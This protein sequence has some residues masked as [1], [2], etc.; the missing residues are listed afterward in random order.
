MARRPV[1]LRP[2]RVSHYTSSA[3]TSLRAEL[4]LQSD[5]IPVELTLGMGGLLFHYGEGMQ[6]FISPGIRGEG[7]F[8]DFTLFGQYSAGFIGETT[9][10]A[11]GTERMVVP[12][13]MIH[14]PVFE[15]EHY[16]AAHFGVSYALRLGRDA[17]IRFL[18]ALSGMAR[19]SEASELRGGHF[20]TDFGL[21]VDFGCITLYDMTTVMYRSQRDY[22]Q[23]WKNLR[24]A[25]QR[26]MVGIYGD[27][28]PAGFFAEYTYDVFYHE[29][30]IGARIAPLWGGG[31]SIMGRAETRPFS[32]WSVGFGVDVPLGPRSR[33]GAIS[34][35]V[36]FS[37]GTDGTRWNYEGLKEVSLSIALDA[38]VHMLGHDENA[39]RAQERVME[40]TVA[41]YVHQS[42]SDET[43]ER[44]FGGLDEYLEAQLP[45]TRGSSTV[46]RRILDALRDGENF[47]DFCVRA[48]SQEDTV[49]DRVRIAAG[50][51]GLGHLYY[52]EELLESRRTSGRWDAASRMNHESVY[53]NI[54]RSLQNGYPLSAGVCAHINGLAAEF[55]RRAGVDAWTASVPS[56]DTRHIVSVALDQETG[57]SYVVD[58]GQVFEVEGDFIEAV[59]AYS[60]SR[61]FRPHSIYVYGRGGSYIGYYL[62]DSGR[63]IN[64]AVYPVGGRTGRELIRRLRRAV[65]R[66]VEQE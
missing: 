66:R 59:R 55:L 40:S 3:G 7:S 51:A 47:G 64:R 60:H 10:E 35:E 21:A 2:P 15:S 39:Q 63:L 38:P 5:Y 1:A 36:E 62:D 41:P 44:Y 23:H 27:A 54:R 30:R 11:R 53:R 12:A 6:P 26:N 20:E 28:G 37:P 43:L 24:P 16:H 8:G 17:S 65:P 46:R 4:G 61:G 19:L 18:A 34:S 13:R 56:G 9:G 45:S 29:G 25:F 31:I 52:D 57:N 14:E 33:Y 42:L 22:Q 48:T 49:L 32:S 58:Y 50:L